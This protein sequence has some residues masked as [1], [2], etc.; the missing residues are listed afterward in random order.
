MIV[1]IFILIIALLILVHELG[2][3]IMAKRAGVRVEEFGIG[4][5]PRIFSFKKN[6]TIYSLNLLPLGGFVKIYGEDSTSSEGAGQIPLSNDNFMAKSVWQRSKIIIAGVAMNLLLAVFLLSIGYSLGLPTAVDDNTAGA[7]VQITQVASNSPAEAAGVK[8]GDTIQK[9]QISNFQLPITNVKEFQETIQQNKG[10]EVMLTIQRGDQNLSIVVT[11]REN[12]PAGEGALGVGLANIAM[13]SYPWHETI[14]KGIATTFNLFV[15]IFISLGN[16]I[17]QLAALHHTVQG[18]VAGPVGIFIL[19]DQ[20]SKIGFI[21]LLQFMVLLSVNLAVINILPLPALDG[22]RLLFLLI[23]K[24]KG[25][26]VKRETERAIH[27]VGF[28]ILIGLMVLVTLRD[29]VK[30]F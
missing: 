20:F 11:P 17:W 14:I 9:L 25:S 4:F 8:M 27:S 10:K 7:R 6:E 28:V 3:F 2:H 12:P 30:L 26:P 15:A 16:L 18:E 24:I 19:A 23:E 21:Y 29:V 5:P 22:G 13:V 1:L